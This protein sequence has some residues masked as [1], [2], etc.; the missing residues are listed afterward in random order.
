MPLRPKVPPEA[1]VTLLLPA[2]LR[3][4]K[5]AVACAVIAPVACT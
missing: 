1:K 2:R 5:V 3:S 4:V